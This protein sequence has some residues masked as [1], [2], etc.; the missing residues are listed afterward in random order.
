MGRYADGKS[1]GKLWHPVSRLVDVV[2]GAKDHPAAEEWVSS[3]DCKEG[4]GSKELV[5]PAVACP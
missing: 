2:P 4:W 5:L 3:N 1:H